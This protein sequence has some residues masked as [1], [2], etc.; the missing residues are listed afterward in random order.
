MKNVHLVEINFDPLWQDAVANRCFEIGLQG[1]E[2]FEEGPI[3]GIRTYC[4]TKTEAKELARKI[5]EYLN[6]LSLLWPGAAPFQISTGKIKD[7]DWANAWKANFKP[8]EVIEN[9]VVRPSWEPYHSEKPEIVITID[10]KMAFGTGKHETTTLALEAI[11]RFTD[12]YELKDCLMLDLGCGTGI[13]GLA[14]NFMGIPRTIGID[15]D[16]EAINCAAE[17]AV[18][19]GLPD[20]SIF[21]NVPLE[22]IAGLFDFIVANIDAPTLIR[23]A[24]EIKRVFANTGRVAL[25]GI[26]ET[27][28]Q[29][30]EDA[31]RNVGFTVTDYHQRGEWILLEME[32]EDP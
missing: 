27:Q 12:N 17:N 21:I 7:M 24:P 5:E 2:T 19:N 16:P 29:K 1:I 31:Y 8:T 26:L 20:R 6:N 18:I 10:P 22:N 25:T 3:C 30:I 11:K 28:G 32:V 13:L 9:L 23:L 4:A 15:I 14:A